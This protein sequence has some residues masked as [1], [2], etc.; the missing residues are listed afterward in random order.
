MPDISE[1]PETKMTQSYILSIIR[2]NNDLK[3]VD[4]VVELISKRVYEKYYLHERF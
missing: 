1:I 3:I 2:D 4:K